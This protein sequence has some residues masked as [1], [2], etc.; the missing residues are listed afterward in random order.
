MKTPTPHSSEGCSRR[1]RLI[2]PFSSTLWCFST[3]NFNLPPLKLILL[4]GGVRLLPFLSTT[5]KSQHKTRL[6]LN[7]V[8]RQ[9]TA[10]FQLLT[11]ECQP[12]LSRR[13]SLL[14]LDLGFYISYSVWGFSL[15]RD[16]L[17]CKGPHKNLHCGGGSI[18][19]GG[20]ERK[21]PSA[22][23]IRTTF[24]W[25]GFQVQRFSPIS[26]WEHDSIQASMVLRVLH[27]HLLLEQVVR[28]KVW[29]LTPTVTHFLQLGHTHS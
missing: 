9:S 19:D 23:L 8:V 2:L 11:S 12:L 1:S 17:L 21:S 15:E 25:A 24:S 16:G 6:L 26:R 20:S 22:M 4:G 27:L 5:T 18:H 13:N 28:R 7:A 14:I 29:K 3:A 10:I